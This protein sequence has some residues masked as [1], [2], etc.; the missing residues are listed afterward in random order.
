MA[1]AHTVICDM[2]TTIAAHA[3]D[4]ILRVLQQHSPVK[5]MHP[6]N[7]KLPDT[8]FDPNEVQLAIERSLEVTALSL[9]ND[10][11]LAGNILGIFS[12]KTN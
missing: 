3:Q 11:I 1:T 8:S 6:S 5:K 10:P 7:Q 2:V 4:S 9:A 12:S